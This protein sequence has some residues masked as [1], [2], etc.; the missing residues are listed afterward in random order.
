MLR[1]SKYLACLISVL[2]CAAWV[3]PVWGAESEG[4][5]PAPMM[6]DALIVRPVGVVATIVGTAVFIVTLP[7]SVP[8]ASVNKAAK[9]LV[10]DPFL[11]TFDRPLGEWPRPGES[12][13]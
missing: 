1:R 10:G 7:F 13:Y 2:L 3:A 12:H 4:G 9:T 5:D 11:F 6:L 8:T